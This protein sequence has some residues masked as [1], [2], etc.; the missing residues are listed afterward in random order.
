MFR[1]LVVAAILL[2]TPIHCQG[3]VVVDDPG[4]NPEAATAASAAQYDFQARPHV[5]A[6]DEVNE[7]DRPRTK[8]VYDD[9]DTYQRNE[10]NRD[11]Y[12]EDE[13]PSHEGSG[14]SNYPV[15]AAAAEVHEPQ[16]ELIYDH[17]EQ[18]KPQ[19]RQDSRNEQSPD[20]FDGSNRSDP[21]QNRDTR[22]ESP[23][24]EVRERKEC[25]VAADI[26]A[27]AA[28]VFAPVADLF[29][30]ATEP[31]ARAAVATAA[32]EV[33]EPQ[34][35]LIYDRHEQYKPQ[36]RQ[37]S[38]NEQ[39]PDHFDG[40]NRSDPSQNR[41]TRGESPAREVRERK[42][43][44]AAANVFAHI[45]AAA[46]TTAA[47]T[48]ADAE[49]SEALIMPEYALIMPEYVIQDYPKPRDHQEA[50]SEQSPDNITIEDNI[51][52]SAPESPPKPM[53]QH[54]LQDAKRRIM[55]KAIGI[56][57][58]E[59]LIIPDVLPPKFEPEFNISIKF[60][61]K[62][63]DMGQLLTINE[64]RSE[65]TI[66]FDAQPGQIFTLAMVDPDSPSNTRH[67]YR[68]YRHFLI[69]NLEKTENSTS[70][71]ITTYQ[72]PQ[73]EFGTGAHRYVIVVL[74]QRSR[75]NMTEADVPE[76]RVR[77][78]VVDWGSK[79]RMKPVAASYFMVKRNH[80]SE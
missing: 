55:L 50:H 46:N 17:H 13:R 3:G 30:H 41:D 37:D 51:V 14:R 80:V 22:G 39:S 29:A 23:A 61:K 54:H 6:A 34:A 71:V 16:T 11:R 70:S 47:A 65:P 7:H 72:S 78:D 19:I 45:A 4:N 33:H 28:S 31:F 38:R 44:P 40:S 1:V 66:E 57:L 73:P 42:E 74:R 36:I 63:V 69:S 75:F 12:G 67:G 43:Y 2:G 18:Y 27:P 56:E 58:A 32:A 10:L 62:L 79:R 8:F 35:E 59:T 20:H 25:P 24:R 21:N 64:T 77:F 49:A 9:Y 76:S 26:F 5:R 15:V 48:A 60:N 52:D 53:V 68:S